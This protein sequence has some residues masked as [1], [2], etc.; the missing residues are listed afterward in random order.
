MM[1]SFIRVDHFHVC[2]PPNRLEEAKD[3]YTKVIGLELIYRPDHLFSSAG[4]WL[5]IGD[6]QLHIGVEPALPRSIRHVAMAVVD[7]DAAR[8][9][10]QDNEVEIIEEP[11]IPGRKRFA[12]I[13]PFGN[14]MELL[15]LL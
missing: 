12:F 5:N 1:I 6:V 9:H 4:Y 14:R 10:L 3:F 7:V 8:K 2:V 15:Q 11:V 13:D